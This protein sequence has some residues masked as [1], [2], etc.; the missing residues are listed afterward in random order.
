M[1]ESTGAYNLTLQYR[2]GPE[3]PK[4][5]IT[6]GEGTLDR[7]LNAYSKTA[8]IATADLGELTFTEAGV[9][10]LSIT[11]AGHDKE[12]R[13]DSYTFGLD[14]LQIV[15][16]PGVEAERPGTVCTVGGTLDLSG[17]ISPSHMQQAYMTAASL[18]WQIRSETAFDV[19]EVDESGRLRAHNP[20]TAV[21]RVSN[22]YAPAAYLDFVVTVLDDSA[23]DS[24]QAAAA[25]IAELG[26]PVRTDAFAEKLMAAETLLSGL[27][28][29]DQK[30][31]TGAYLLKAARYTYDQLSSGTASAARA[32]YYLEDLAYTGQGALTKGTCPSGSHKIQ[33]AEDGEIYEHG[34]GF[35]PPDGY[36]G[37]LL[38]PVPANTDVFRARVGVDYAMSRNNQYDQQ[39]QLT[40]YLDGKQAAQ[41]GVLKSNFVDGKWV[42]TYV[43]DIEIP[44]PA[45]SKW[46]YI[47]NFIGRDRNCDHILL[48]D[49]RFENQ[50]AAHVE[51]L[52][53]DIAP[54]N[55]NLDHWS[56][57][58]A[59]K[60]REAET[61]YR[62]LSA[63]ERSMVSNRNVLV[64]HRQTHSSFGLPLISFENYEKVMAVADAIAAVQTEGKRGV[65]TLALAEAAAD[66][67]KNL[68]YELTD[69]LPDLF[70]LYDAQWW[71]EENRAGLTAAQPGKPPGPL[72][73]A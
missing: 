61:A 26:T 12:N 38:V 17:F 68:E 5:R 45:G 57:E 20:G 8:S 37:S 6:D 10:T 31:A 46:L 52:I 33:F 4:L 7:T 3:A 13:A 1:V 49:A 28:A 24:L 54:E 22:Q 66:A 42:D 70:R 29:A 34:M 15:S 73:Q 69:Y 71:I 41:T 58:T 25:A 9:K 65:S 32:T 14:S 19:A 51:A 27:T 53:G 40:F 48:A 11:V 43:Y 60:I 30:L 64:S 62:A 2:T 56:S 23:S 21:L 63:L 44:I 67:L 59:D 16:S 39:N 55:V 72:M 36:N 18:R 35:E 50:A 47:K